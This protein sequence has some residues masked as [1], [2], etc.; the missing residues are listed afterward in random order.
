MEL[1]VT[2][3]VTLAPIRFAKPGP[4]SKNPEP[5]VDVPL[6]VTVVEDW[7]PAAFESAE[8]GAAG[9]GATSFAT[10]KP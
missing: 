10:S 1:T 9:A 3:P 8:L 7:P 5:D 6:I 2:P 4:G